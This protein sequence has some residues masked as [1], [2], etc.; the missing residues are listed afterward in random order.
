MEMFGTRLG[1][2]TTSVRAVVAIGLVVAVL[3][4][5]TGCTASDIRVQVEAEG[6][7][8]LVAL[9]VVAKRDAEAALIAAELAG[10]TRAVM[11]WR[12]LIPWIE[13]LG[14]YRDAVETAEASGTGYLLKYQRI[15]NA[16]RLIERPPDELEIACSPMLAESSDFLRT[17]ARAAGLPGL[18]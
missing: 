14:E 6:G 18:P 8:P 7:D 3:A 9:S 2:R 11:C 12:A 13:Q 4:M 5:V 17:L 16:R 1:Q 10:D 15:R